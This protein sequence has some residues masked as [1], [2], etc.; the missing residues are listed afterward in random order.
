[1]HYSVTESAGTVKITMVKRVED[2]DLQVGVRTEEGTAK[3]GTDFDGIDQIITFKRNEYEATV[4]IRIHDDDDW[5]PDND[6]FVELYNIKT[7]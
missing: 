1:M 4:E 3:H 5:N 6:F 7:K 2:T